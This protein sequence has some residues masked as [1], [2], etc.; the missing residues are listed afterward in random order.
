MRRDQDKVTSEDNIDNTLLRNVIRDSYRIRKEL[1]LI[2]VAMETAEKEDRMDDQETLRQKWNS[3][4]DMYSKCLNN[5]NTMPEVKIV[6]G[7]F[8]DHAWK[9][10]MSGGEMGDCFFP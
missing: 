9:K 10:W 7:S 8:L 1:D 3:Y 5:W 4:S 6:L 2:H